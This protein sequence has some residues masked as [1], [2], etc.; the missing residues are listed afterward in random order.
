MRFLLSTIC[1]VVLLAVANVAVADNAM[2]S[3]I[4][5]DLVLEASLVGDATILPGQ[6][7]AVKARLV[8]RSKDAVYPAIKP[9][10][11]SECG[12]REPYVF[13]TAERKNDAGEWK[14]ATK[15]RYGRCGLFDHNW[16]KDVVELKPGE[17][18]EIKDWLPTPSFMFE[19]QQAGQW[20]LRVHYR[21]SGG[22]AVKGG[23]GLADDS[24]EDATPESLKGIP[25]FELTSAP[26]EMKLVRP[27][28]VK[29]SVKKNLKIKTSTPLSELFDVRLINA[30]KESQTLVEPTV[31]GDA[32]LHFEIDG[33]M[34][35]WAPVIDPSSDSKSVQRTL[36]PGRG[37]SLLGDD[38]RIQGA[39]EYP[40]EDTV[41]VR[42]VYTTSTWKPGSVVMSDWVEIEV[43]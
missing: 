16:Q 9:G 7:I 13:Y 40:V 34:P 12:W 36:K 30:S 22:A 41:R 27:L 38:A 29:I 8:N 32:R 25:T 11:G 17:S 26:I 37:I 2:P 35:G 5:H 24:G 28:D 1:C 14:P 18:I 39:W 6:Q 19:I 33:E 3:N 10:D 20:R 42:A 15:T 4:Q 21:Y 43:K 31:S 23:K